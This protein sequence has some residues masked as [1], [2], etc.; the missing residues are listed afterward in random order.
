MFRPLRNDEVLPKQSY[1]KG[2]KG[3]SLRESVASEHAGKE[4]NGLISD[5]T[6][7]KKKKS[8]S[9]STNKEK[10]RHESSKEKNE[11]K[12][13]HKKREEHN[14][15]DDDID[16]LGTPV[17]GKT[18]SSKSTSSK[19]KTKKEKKSTKEKKSSKDSSL[20]NDGSKSGYEEALGISTPSKEIYWFEVKSSF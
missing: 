1:K 15:G 20:L 8:K 4:K 13:K 5:S 6:A 12:K 7:V 10:S 14:A 16:L 3:E 17:K 19:D 18:K 2:I 9:H 11:H